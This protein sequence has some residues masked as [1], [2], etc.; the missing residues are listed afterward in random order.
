MI[1]LYTNVQNRIASRKADIRDEG[2]TMVE[3]GLIVAVIALVVVVGA[4][5]FGDDL[6]KFF[7]DLGGNLEETP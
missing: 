4:G 1:K 7:N 5:V 6:S 3:Y 2:A